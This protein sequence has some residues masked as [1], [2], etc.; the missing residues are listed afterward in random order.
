M[1]ENILALF[2][3]I[4][5]DMDRMD[6]VA[7]AR[8]G[9]SRTDFR[10]LDILSR[11]NSMTPGQLAEETGLSSGATTALLDRLEKGGFVRRKRDVKDRRRVFVLP[12]KRSIDEV[13]PIFEG[14][15]AGVTRLMGQFRLEELET[16]L[17]FL[18]R[19]RTVIRE[20]LPRIEASD[21]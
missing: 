14:L 6:E 8:L 10:C 20:H 11:G 3:A 18:E 19:Q 16:I 12:T 9:I 1:T 5:G 21:S 7:A 15:V 2:R 17:R 13:W 4:D